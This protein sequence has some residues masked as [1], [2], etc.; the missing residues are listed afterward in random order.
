MRERWQR[1]LWRVLDK[2]GDRAAF[3]QRVSSLLRSP[4]QVWSEAYRTYADAYR[5]GFLRLLEEIL[6]MLTPAQRDH[7]I[8]RLRRWANDMVDLACGPE[9]RPAS[10]PARP[11]PGDR[12]AGQVSFAP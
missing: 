5:E 11:L 8:R 7:L 1:A 3:D 6:G 4:E 10:D 9:L 2:R 12:L